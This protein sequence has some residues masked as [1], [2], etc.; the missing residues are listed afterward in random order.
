MALLDWDPV[1]T[2]GFVILFLLLFGSYGGAAPTDNL[3]V[4]G[5]AMFIEIPFLILGS[6][7][8]NAWLLLPLAVL[9]MFVYFNGIANF[10]G[11]GMLALMIVAYLIVMVGGW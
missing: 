11:E 6:I 8:A 1:T 3:I 5:A 2:V 9:A 10:A 4:Q 7:G